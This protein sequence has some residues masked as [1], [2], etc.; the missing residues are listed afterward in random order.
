VTG[1][2]TR[3]KLGVRGIACRILARATKFLLLSTASRP[4]LGPTRLPIQSLQRDL[5]PG[6][7]RPGREAQQS[8]HLLPRLKISGLYPHSPIDVNVMYR[9]NFT[10][11]STRCLFVYFC[12]I[13][14]T[15]PYANLNF[16]VR[17]VFLCL[18]KLRDFRLPP[19]CEICA[20]LQC[21]T[22]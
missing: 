20:L 22:A 15:S 11:A 9:D 7:K 3:R 5:S 8:L 10:Y 17:C 13:C 16:F 1:I 18:S 14:G 21:H 12:T 19:W 4:T 2:V 6:K